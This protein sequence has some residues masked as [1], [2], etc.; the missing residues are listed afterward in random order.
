MTPTL[1]SP[2]D[3]LGDILHPVSARK[4]SGAP[5]TKEQVEKRATRKDHKLPTAKERKV[6]QLVEAREGHEP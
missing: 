5:P 4:G 3:L 6:K 2:T 1:S